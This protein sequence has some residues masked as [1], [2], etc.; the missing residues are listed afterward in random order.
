M[1][2][3]RVFKSP[4]TNIYMY[5]VNTWCMWSLR[6]VG[7][8]ITCFF[9]CSFHLPFAHYRSLSRPCTA[10]H[11]IKKR[12]STCQFLLCLDPVIFPSS[13]KSLDPLYTN[14]PIAESKQITHINLL[15]LCLPV[16][17]PN[18]SSITSLRAVG[19]FN[20]FIMQWNYPNN[21]CS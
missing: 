20:S 1:Y 4:R 16:I 14:P 10:T 19:Y 18:M 13:V 3:C 15:V 12:L 7:D 9:C 17:S 21:I 11:R 8:N 2:I 5:C 6:P